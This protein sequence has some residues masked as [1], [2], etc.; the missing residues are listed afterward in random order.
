MILS[1]SLSRS[2]RIVLFLGMFIALSS[3]PAWAQATSTSAVSGLVTDQSGAAIPDA[4]VTLIDT[5]TNATQTASTNQAGRYIFVNVS[6]GSY[7]VV[8]TKS[9]FNTFKVEAQKVEVGTAAT[10]NATLE[11]GSTAT[12]VEAPSRAISSRCSITSCA[13]RS[14]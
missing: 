12:T 2:V 3:M 10:V 8:F 13:A 14:A 9:G 6:P 4:T 11:V 5:A 7:R 1:A